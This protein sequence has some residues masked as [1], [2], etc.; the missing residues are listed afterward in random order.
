MSS[1]LTPADLDR[2]QEVC[3]YFQQWSRFKGIFSTFVIVYAVYLPFTFF[4][5]QLKTYL[6]LKKLF[7]CSPVLIIFLIHVIYLS[8]F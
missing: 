5:L 3:N 2:L 1:K 4:V 7:F 8:T 6:H